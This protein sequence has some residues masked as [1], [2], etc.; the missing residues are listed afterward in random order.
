MI[1]FERYNDYI[2]IWC[3]VQHFQKCKWQ[4]EIGYNKKMMGNV[5]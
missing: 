2:L 5:D 1:F 3:F 4:I